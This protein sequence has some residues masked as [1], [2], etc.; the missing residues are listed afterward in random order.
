VPL[1]AGL[2]HQALAFAV[3]AMA[4]VHVTRTTARRSDVG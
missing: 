4:V 3:L 2:A 1:W